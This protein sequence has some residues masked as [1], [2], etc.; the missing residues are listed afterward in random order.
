MKNHVIGSV[1]I[2]FL[3]LGLTPALGSTGVGTPQPS[4]TV[5]SPTLD[6]DFPTRRSLVQFFYIP[7]VDG[8]SNLE[9]YLSRRSERDILTTHLETLEPEGRS[10]EI[11]SAFTL[12]IPGESSRI[13]FIIAK[14]PV[15]HAA[16]GTEGNLYKVLAYRTSGGMGAQLDVR[17]ATEIEE[18]LGPGFDGTLEG[19]RSTY[20]YKDFESVRQALSPKI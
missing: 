19:E 4:L 14:W 11:A 17:R 12:N 20:R 1:L 18:R 16:I 5:A 2:L 10:A 7:Q 6:I 8:E 15:R 3:C 13:F 9:I